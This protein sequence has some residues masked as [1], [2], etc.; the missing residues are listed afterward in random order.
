MI[1]DAVAAAHGGM[2]SLCIGPNSWNWSTQSGGSYSTDGGWNPNWDQEIPEPR[3]SLGPARGGEEYGAQE[4]QGESARWFERLW[5]GHLRSE[6]NDEAYECQRRWGDYRQTAPATS[7]DWCRQGRERQARSWRRRGAEPEW[8]KKWHSSERL[9]GVQMLS[10][11]GLRSLR[12]SWTP[13]E[14]P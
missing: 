1:R 14:A 8:T 12:Q 6:T 7:G 3:S 5:R 2:Q 13:V 9:R 10:G 11:T 4:G